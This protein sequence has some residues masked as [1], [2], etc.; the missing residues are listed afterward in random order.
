MFV[1]EDTT[2]RVT[3]TPAVSASE[4]TTDNALAAGTRLHEFEV[5]RVI[6]EGG[7]SLVY[8]AFDHVLHR[9]VALK[10][11][12][13]RAL[14]SRRHDN[15]VVVHS[16][17]LRP[18]FEAGMRSFINEARLLAQFDHPALVKVYRFWEGNATA[19]MA[20]P[21]YQGRTLKQVLKDDPARATQAWLK[22]VFAPVQDALALLH[23]ER[24]YHRDISPDNIQLLANDAPVLLDLGAARRTISDQTQAF[25]AI[26][27][28]SYAP[29]EQYADDAQMKQ[30]PWT[31]VYALAAV[32]YAAITHKPPPP[33]VARIYQDPLQPLASGAWTGFDP[34]FL[35]AIDAALAVRPDE[36][37]R[38]MHDFARALG[39]PP[40][41]SAPPPD[42]VATRTRHAPVDE[43]TLVVDDALVP[44]PQ[45]EATVVAGEPPTVLSTAASDARHIVTPAEVDTAA[46]D[47][48]GLD[49]SA[50]DA[51][52]NASALDAS[53]IDASALDASPIEAPA[54]GALSRAIE[55]PVTDGS[56]ASSTV[57]MPPT[58]APARSARSS[59]RDDATIVAPRNASPTAR[60]VDARKRTIRLTLGAVAAI[61]V[62]GYA[63]WQ[64]TRNHDAADVAN[65][66]AATTAPATSTT[67]APAAATSPAKSSS[68]APAPA[69]TTAPG[70]SSTVAP[71]SEPKPTPV[72]APAAGA[73]MPEPATAAPVT[74]SPEPS[75][76]VPPIVAPPRTA[77]TPARAS[78]APAAA[79][80]ASATPDRPHDAEPPREGRPARDRT[81]SPKAAK[82]VPSRPAADPPAAD[83][84]ATVPAGARQDEKCRTLRMRAELGETLTGSDR[85]ALEKECR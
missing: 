80:A 27:K 12:I 58:D 74:P 25:T 41:R 7:F 79:P 3:G 65:T 81:E 39:M 17:Q 26:L 85:S 2:G 46:L 30:G 43:S 47:M 10:E 14:A 63:A 15:T 23:A 21:L 70:T 83:A 9:E 72:A 36:R 50:I 64:A 1:M 61:V 40:P 82:V 37:T 8:L 73:T 77:S 69:A 4:P 62:L 57:R 67:A 5:R 54:F 32:M 35:R 75:S 16:A 20:M 29:L 68:A 84:R 31:D 42:A 22:K 59:A 34:S 56:T 52:A 55:G 48:R 38:S 76:A 44:T 49:A 18:T 33:S 28:P 51:S 45:S 19:Y 6:G 53:A 78:T 11:Y 13:P 66:P 71:A 24:C 60:P